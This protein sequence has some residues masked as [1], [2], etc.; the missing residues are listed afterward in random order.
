[1]QRDLHNDMFV[2]KSLCG[3][4]RGQ[5]SLAGEEGSLPSSSSSSL[6][7]KPAFSTPLPYPQGIDSRSFSVYLGINF[8]LT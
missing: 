1:M 6:S 7:D 5:Q 8:F 3:L 2:Q 4:L